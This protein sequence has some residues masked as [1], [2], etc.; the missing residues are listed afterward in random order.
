M[1]VF[2]TGASGFIGSAVVPELLQAGHEVVGLA[3][4]DASAR[5][6]LAAGAEVHRGS[7]DDPDDLGTAAAAADGVIHLAFVH[8]FANF[9][10]AAATDAR[11]IEAMA[12]AL[13]GSE[14][15]LVIAS[16]VLV[17]REGLEAGGAAGPRA[18][19]ARAAVAAAAR[20]VRSSVVG[21][22]PSVH[23]V[24]DTGFVPRLIQIAR[25]TGVSGYVGDGANRWPAVHRT[26]AAR[27]FR[28]ALEKAPGAT[29]LPATADEG[30]PTRTIAEVIGRRLNV[31]TAAIEPERALDHFG[32]IGPFFSIDAATSSAT[33]REILGWEPTGPGLI[34]DL[35]HGDYFEN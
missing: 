17:L 26:D 4:S 7:L 8:D 2:V 30:I 10:R 27:L 29:I 21:L 1:R 12:E 33:T 9:A 14:R 6:L 3:R 19:G 5:A 31:P 13:E 28:L 32:W 11:A 35:E 16:G 15:P 23:D 20:G 18:A 24:S 34:E 22:P 25:D